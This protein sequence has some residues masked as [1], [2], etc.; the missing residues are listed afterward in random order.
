MCA[1]YMTKSLFIL[2][3]ILSLQE[4]STPTLRMRSLILKNYLLSGDWEAKEKQLPRSE[5]NLA[6]RSI[7]ETTF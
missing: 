2:L 7:Q 3:A 6:F 4:I 5:R 1:M